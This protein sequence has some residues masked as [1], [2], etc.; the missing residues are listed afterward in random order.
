SR[1][2]HGDRPQ[3]P[4]S[5]APAQT[6]DPRPCARPARWRMAPVHRS[7]VH[8]EP[9]VA[10]RARPA[11]PAAVSP[12]VRDASALRE[13]TAGG[14]AFRAGILPDAEAPSLAVCAGG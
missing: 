3:R 10:P 1:L 6:D 4:L 8:R 5:G 9:R 7:A 12:T 2:R 14:S 11:A 13:A